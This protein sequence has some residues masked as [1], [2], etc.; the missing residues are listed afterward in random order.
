M[1]L[2]VDFQDSVLYISARSPFARRVRL[3]LLENKIRFSEKVFDVFNPLPELITVNP[4][5]RVPAL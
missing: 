1:S 4:L 5:A 3:A 2:G